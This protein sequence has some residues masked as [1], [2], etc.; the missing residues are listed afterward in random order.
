MEYG[1]RSADREPK[2][3]AGLARRTVMMDG[4][5]TTYVDEG[6][7][8]TVVLLHGAPFTAIGFMRVIAELAK[9]HRVVAPD[10]PGFGG[11]DVPPGFRGA[12]GDYAAFVVAF[13]GALGLD[14]FALY[15]NDS[16]TCF[17][18][19]AAAEMAPRVAGLVVA[20]TVPIPLTGA[21]VLVKIVLA[22]VLSSRL[23]RFLNRKLNLLPWLVATLA[24]WLRPFSSAERRALTAEFD[25]PEKRERVLDLFQQVGKDDAFMHAAARLARE[26]LAHAPVLILYGQLDPM[27]W[28][29]GPRR[30]R[31]LFPRHASA[32]V[33]A[34]EHFPIFASG[35][36]VGAIVHE[37][38]TSVVGAQHKAR[39]AMH[40]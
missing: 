31:A 39:E 17:G 38:M 27:R 32:V 25:T 4:A 16:I 30:F 21:A 10:L 11:S 12:L 36:R 28:I 8:P 37:W 26:R 13:C 15:T 40:G 7:G 33:P 14:D 9:H 2:G 29:G 1:L 3:R 18:I 6:R 24:P 34:E 35:A 23:V 22:H 19:L 5:R 20:D